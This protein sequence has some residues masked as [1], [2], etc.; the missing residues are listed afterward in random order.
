MQLWDRVLDL[1]GCDRCWNR[2][3][4][5]MTRSSV[6][7]CTGKRR[8]VSGAHSSCARSKTLQT[9]LDPF[10]TVEIDG[11]HEAMDK[12]PRLRTWV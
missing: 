7:D 8:R 6:P 2:N 10:A 4:H 5:L 9:D 11:L 1:G 3:V 12:I